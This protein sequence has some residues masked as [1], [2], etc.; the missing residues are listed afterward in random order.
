MLAACLHFSA[1]AQGFQCSPLAHGKTECILFDYHP[2]GPTVV[3]EW[4]LGN[5]ETPYKREIQG[6]R[7]GRLLM[8]GA[9]L[10]LGADQS[11]IIQL[12]SG[13]SVNL[14]E[15]SEPI[16][17]TVHC[18][19]EGGYAWD[20]RVTKREVPTSMVGIATE[21]EMKLDLQLVRKQKR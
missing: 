8:G 15:D 19:L 21:G 20:I 16:P 14:I 7:S 2:S 6:A 4:R 11:W 12:S 17:K 13:S 3:R 18:V 5:E 9:R 10:M 1:V